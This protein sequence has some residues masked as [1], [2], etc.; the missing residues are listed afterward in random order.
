VV[1]HRKIYCFGLLDDIKDTFSDIIKGSVE[2][3]P[4]D[5]KNLSYENSA[6][7]SLM[8]SALTHAMAKRLE[9]IRM[10]EIAF[11]KHLRI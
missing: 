2:R 5:E 9:S 3:V 6:M 11:G 8:K 1:P 4:V 7:T 10:V